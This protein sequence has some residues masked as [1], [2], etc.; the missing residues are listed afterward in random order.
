[1]TATQAHVGDID[2]VRTTR[3]ARPIPGELK[4]IHDWLHLMH[5]Y[6]GV[7]PALGQPGGLGSK[8]AHSYATDIG[9]AGQNSVGRWGA[10]M[11]GSGPLGTTLLVQQKAISGSTAAREQSR[12][13]DLFWEHADAPIGRLLCAGNG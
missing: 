1:M 4:M 5:H 2:G 8:E 9:A 11:D 7:D 10:A 3:S 12:A 6:W 13:T